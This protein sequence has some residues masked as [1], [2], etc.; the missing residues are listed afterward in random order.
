MAQCFHTPATQLHVAPPAPGKRGL[1]RH[2]NVHLRHN[3]GRRSARPQVLCHVHHSEAAS[4]AKPADPVAVP[5]GT[6][7]IG[8]VVM[9][10]ETVPEGH[11]GL[12]GF[13]YGDNGAGGGASL[14]FDT[15]IRQPQV[16][17]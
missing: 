11:Q 8:A 17:G 4:V 5:A 15:S 6:T 12:H 1:G 13:L 9:T 7:A 14:A 3:Q 10:D 16:H 2:A